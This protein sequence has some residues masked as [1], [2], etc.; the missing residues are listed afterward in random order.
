MSVIKTSAVP[1]DST[2]SPASGGYFYG[3]LFQFLKTDGV[4]GYKSF[5]YADSKGIPTLGV[6]YALV[7]KGKHGAWVVRAKYDSELENSGIN[8][9]ATQL[10][11]L[12]DDLQ[13]AANA[14]N[15]KGNAKSPFK[16]NSPI[17]T[18]EITSSQ[19]ESLFDG[20]INEYIQ[21]VKS[22][23][24][25]SPAGV[26]AFD[27]LYNDNYGSRELI[28]IASQA[29]NS[30]ALI[31]PG[32]SPSLRAAILDGN[33][34]EAWY[35]IRYNDPSPSERRYAEAA[36]FG[37]YQGD[38]SAVSAGDALQIYQMCTTHGLGAMQRYDDQHYKHLHDAEII[39]FSDSTFPKAE[40]LTTILMPAAQALSTLYGDGETFDSM[41]IFAAPSAGDVAISA[42]VNPDHSAP[43]LLIAAGGNDT[44]SGSNADDVLVAS[45]GNDLLEGG[46]GNDR[47]DLG[48]LNSATNVT[49]TI[50]DSDGQGS[51]WVGGTHLA[52]GSSSTGSGDNSIWIA[53]DGT[54]YVFTPLVGG[55]NTNVGTLTIS[56][57]SLGSGD[58]I[59]IDDFDLTKA[60]GDKSGYLGIHLKRALALGAGDQQ[61]SLSNA[62]LMA[63]TPQT[64]T[65]ANGATQTFTV[66]A[67]TV[68][69]K[70]QIVQ[71]GASGSGEYALS[72]GSQ[73]IPL[74]GTVDVTIPA[75]QSRAT[76]TLVDLSNSDQ[77]DSVQLT[78][79]AADVD[80]SVTSN[81]LTVNFNAPSVG[82]GNNAPVGTLT[83]P[84]IYAAKDGHLYFKYYNEEYNKYRIVTGNTNSYVYDSGQYDTVIGG[85]GND[86]LD[87]PELVGSSTSTG[88]NDVVEGGGG[89]DTLT[90]WWGNNEIYADTKTSIA[91][92]LANR[93]G[94]STEAKGSLIMVGGGNNLVVGGHGN[95]AILTGDGSNT[96][97]CGPGADT[98]I[99]GVFH[100]LGD[101]LPWPDG[102]GGYAQVSPYSA[103]GQ[104][105]ASETPSFVPFSWSITTA[106]SGWT[107]SGL[108][109]LF[110]DST[111]SV[112]SPYHG[113]S[114]SGVP[115]GITN[116]TIFGGTGDSF[117]QLSNGD[118]YLDAGGGNDTILAGIGR[119]TIYGGAGNDTIDG[120]GGDNYIATEA[121]NDVVVAF[122]GNNTIVGGSGNDT[123]ISGDNGAKWA[124]SETSAKNYI[125]SGSGNS[126]ILGSGG[127]DTLVAGSGN[128]S[129]Y[130]GAGKELIEGGAGK[131]VLASGSTATAGSDTVIAGSGDSTLY[132]GTGADF[133]YGG[134]GTDVIH[135]GSGATVIYAGDGGTTAAPTQVIVG[136]GDTTVHGGSGVDSIVGGSGADTLIAG[137]GAA[138][139]LGGSGTD[140]LEAGNGADVLAAGSGADTL[141][142]GLGE[143]TLAGGSGSNTLIAGKGADTLVGGSG[144]NVYE[145][146]AGFGSA[147]IRP[148]SSNDVLRFGDG[149]GLSDL[150]VTGSL[151][152]AAN[153]V[154]DIHVADGGAVSIDGGLLGTLDRYEVSGTLYTAQQLIA[155]V[156][157]L[158]NDAEGAQGDLLFSAD[159]GDSLTGTGGEDTLAA[160]GANT[161]L[162]GGGGD[163]LFIVND[164]SEVVAEPNAGL[165]DT[166]QSSVSYVLPE[167][168]DLLELAGYDDLT[169][170]GNDQTDVITA[171]SGNDTL[172]AGAGIATLVGGAGDDTF[173]VNNAADVVQA[174][175]ISNQWGTDNTNA[176]DTSVSY[177]MPEHVQNLTGVGSADIVLTGGA[178]DGEIITANSGNDTLIAGTGVAE[179][180][181][182]AG[183][184]T[185]VVN[186]VKDT[187]YAQAGG[188]GGTVQT[189][190]SFVMPENVQYLSGTGGADIELTAN[191]QKGATVTAN[192]GND[193][194]AGGGGS[195][196]LVGG[197]GV[198]TFVLGA[199]GRYTAEKQASAD[200]VV[201]LMP[202]LDLASDVAATRSGNDLLLT[203]GDTSSLKLTGYF[204]NPQQ[205]TIEDSL[206][207]TATGSAL[208]NATANDT[209]TPLERQEKIFET[210]VKERHVANLISE[211]Y[212]QQSD[213]SW[214][215]APT[216]AQAQV[217]AKETQYATTMRYYW[218]STSG[219]E[220]VTTSST[221]TGND[222]SMGSPLVQDTRVSFASKVTDATDSVIYATAYAS[223]TSENNDWL[224]IKW[225]TS[226]TPQKTTATH[227][228]SVADAGGTAV[229]P[230]SQSSGGSQTGWVLVS[231]AQ[232][233][234]ETV[235]YKVGQPDGSV[236]QA[237]LT[238][239]GN[240]SS[241]GSFPQAVP[242]DYYHHSVTDYLQRIDVGVGNHTV[243]GASSTLVNAG[244]GDNL[245]KDAGF[246]VA[247][248]GNDTIDGSGTIFSE[249]GNDLINNASIVYGGSGNDTVY[250]ADSVYGGSGNDLIVG[251]S[252]VVGGTGTD[253]IYGSGSGNTFTVDAN[254]GGIDV[255]GNVGKNVPTTSFVVENDSGIVD[256]KTEWSADTKFLD[257]Y[258][259]QQNISD[260]AERYRYG[261]MY[262][263]TWFGDGVKE[264]IPAQGIQSFLQ[265]NGYDGSVQQALAAG[266]LT[267]YI[268]PLPAA[269]PLVAL[270]DWDISSYYASVGRQV[271]Q[272]IAANDFSALA[273]YFDDGS[274]SA[275]TVKFGAG[276]TRSTLQ[277]SW[278][279]VTTDVGQQ[280]DA[281]GEPVD[282]EPHAALNITWSSGKGVQIIIPHRDD[283]IGSG[284][285]EF[286]FADGTKLSM[287]QMLAL[288]P[289]APT[290][291]PEIFDFKAGMGAQTLP[292]Y[293]QQI[294]FGTGAAPSD[295]AL[296]VDGSDLL[297]S[298]NGGADVLRITGGA[299][300]AAAV[301]ALTYTFA[302]GDTMSYAGDGQGGGTF[303][304]YDTQGD[305]IGDLWVK[306]D[307]SHGT[308]IFNADGSSSGTSYN[309]DGSYSTYT[310]DGQ[311]D[312][313]TKDYSAAGV[314]S[315]DSWSK[316][317][318]SHGTDT[319]NADGSS[320]GTAY[321]ADGSYSTY[322]NDGQ[323]DVTTLA[324][325]ANGQYTGD[326]W[327]R[328]D[329]SH[330]T[331]AFDAA[332]GQFAGSYTLA[333]GSSVVVDANVPAGN[334]PVVS[335]TADATVAGG[336]SSEALFG[337]G[338]GDTLTAGSAG[339]LVYGSGN[340]DVLQSGAGND[341]LIGTGND[342]T[343]VIGAGDGVDT[344]VAAGSGDT[345]VF[346]SGITSDMITLGIGSL[347]L[348]IGPDGQRVHIEG[349]DPS[350]ALGSG[351][352][353]NFRF[354]DGTVL[355]YDQLLARGFDL[356][357]GSGDVSLS[358]TD[359][360]NRL[361]GGSGNDTLIGTGQNDTLYAGSAAD[362]LIGG[363]GHETFVVNNTADVVQ[364]QAGAAGNVVE[365]SVSYAAPANVT[366]LTGT[367]SA[368]IVLTG[369]ALDD[370]IT[371]NSGSDTLVAGG[372]ADTLIGGAGGDTFVVDNAADVVQAQAV[373]GN[374]VETSV[375][376][377]APANVATLTGIGSADITLT[378][379]ALDDTITAN[380]G[381][382]TLVAGSVADTLIGGAGNDTF[383]VNNA[384][385]VVENAGGGTGTVLSSVSYTL[386]GTVQNLTLTGDA[387]IDGTGNAQSNDLTGN[388]GDNVLTG[389]GGN[390][391][392][393]GGAGN[394]TLIGGSG[395]DTFV[396]HKGDG[397]DTL[398]D[399]AG[400]NSVSLGAGL[401][402]QNVSLR[403]YM[404]DGEPYKVDADGRGEV[405]GGDWRRNGTLMLT[406]QLRVL[407]AH[408]DEQPGEGM[409]FTVTLD[410]RGDIVSPIQDFAFA[411][412]S[413]SSFSDL[414][415]KTDTV[416]GQWWDTGALVGG[417]NDDLIFAGP[418]NSGVWAGT[419]NDTVYAAWNGSRVYGGGG[420]DVLVG[421]FGSDTL[422]G[423]W[424][425][426]V[427]EGGAGNDVLSDPGGNS[428][429]FGGWGDDTITAGAGD[430]FIAGGAGD[431]VIA[432]GATD[433]VIAFD[434]GDGNDTLLAAAGADNTLSLGQVRDRELSFSKNGE[435]LVL[436][437]GRGDSVTF[438][439]WYASAANHDVGTL[440]IV[441]GWDQ[442]AGVGAETY[443]FAKLAAEFDRARA[444]DP[445]LNT[446]CLSTGLADAETSS[447]SGTVANRWTRM[448]TRLDVHLQDGDPSVLGG[449]LAYDYAMQGGFGVTD[450]SLA[451]STLR[452]ERF[453]H[454]AQSSHRESMQ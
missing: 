390:D 156:Q 344:I 317:D 5:V 146:D 147:Y 431:D 265:D 346:G 230:S 293:A 291:D 337:F 84:N 102:V 119:N 111:V 137:N 331:D 358:G 357:A 225:T 122:G 316:A 143:A 384:A 335:T 283:P 78:A 414:L 38:G 217:V 89:Q 184:D 69:D 446:W 270:N 206:G 19:A 227:L 314:L 321:N 219:G 50:D 97:I 210:G 444:A 436:H 367:G 191:D 155:A 392:F 27:A 16:H 453:G 348:R 55:S 76:F 58:Q 407:D 59:V 413:S 77:A 126:V 83:S 171:N 332:N 165:N 257:A 53:G 380:S 418:N 198:D 298:A 21:N 264:Y 297:L 117:Y 397:L 287:A 246:V 114:Y 124:T 300:D 295:L 52:G 113:G 99:G 420:D 181:G 411:D 286:E 17:Y 203:V 439:D 110:G 149:I 44:L 37:L 48:A 266:L 396:Y 280:V 275:T 159:A 307:G 107:Y 416:W 249:S 144:Q 86:W 62:L 1:T 254:V 39:P 428:A 351:S 153:L 35:Q 262:L 213:G 239:P 285:Q 327:Q 185:F 355:T 71:I 162:T 250:G 450:P 236:G 312:L 229:T 141:R 161:T 68:S 368:D 342:D 370:T 193:T 221:S 323:G 197:S 308:D 106:A 424:G 42:Q 243:Y 22:W 252:S 318:G 173:V 253:T 289:T 152:A 315:G 75:G 150:S 160:Y 174:Q 90:S 421:G 112:P 24:G 125:F 302:N 311:G 304:E 373:S 406:A 417:R 79:S 273:P 231:A 374:E 292:S 145:L 178:T 361:Y 305:K 345:I 85:S 88:M 132:G 313:T 70:D 136:S 277:F 296:S 350:D 400:Q 166:I 10:I 445:S 441:D 188:G 381:D 212:V 362:T 415:I 347:M 452:D 130:G 182:G 180:D 226:G 189:S 135:G 177:V 427:V 209:E 80:G 366:T 269:A 454:T 410:R 11:R 45:T 412:G 402:A 340:G 303:T 237:V 306:S 261:G 31:G 245:I 195:G 353:Q 240:L 128:A 6:G 329:G 23:L 408:G 216:L 278:S 433:N 423:G 382:D 218:A 151:D 95:D 54:R 394:D 64:A 25:S 279:V 251:A 20:I 98:V 360:D 398:V 322:A 4:E 430:D 158:N 56:G 260:G 377:A 284:I 447:D 94:Q 387:D 319:F 232:T 386:P 256:F 15:K 215:K 352:I 103:E 115:L 208:V 451:Q 200:A 183:N 36:M 301:S 105:L 443:D 109:P 449:A 2:S 120:A 425:V 325:D 33:R 363:Q 211:G 258:Y 378:G 233:T 140:V 43:S 320:S 51:V 192:A 46:A 404:P 281:L 391:T 349:F 372:G 376:Y 129:I 434:R 41:H 8:L 403:L 104:V 154:L 328:A 176:V 12:N 333:S 63:G 235:T 202:G 310:N 272:T 93:S 131:D 28:A 196:T 268:E 365:T 34:A 204:S 401:S 61:L 389:A 60:Q 271:T 263:S 190:V 440:Q 255:I 118:N 435:D 18:W 383:V 100:G 29:Y 92:A 343:F 385:D 194:L 101:N 290:F 448:N 201:K 248:T 167:N 432:T 163:T 133:L 220:R 409:D 3:S 223:V 354:A 234:V 330:G 186:N 244:S 299:T 222:F 108:L 339:D 134:S 32:H 138:T 375:S 276:I 336:S 294:V 7:V 81:Q 238:S 438:K 168:V 422:N 334:T 73:L 123:I 65:V 127:S 356:Y 179:L 187:V 324:Y 199:A 91:T 82:S 207:N 359:L 267:R 399:S 67:S 364:A 175:Q 142:G 170:K 9:S 224:K 139:L 274:L 172:V 419:G 148:V 426:D 241:S 442:W 57:G 309:A 288:A 205:W 429:L 214:Y 116:D 49:D 40:S 72:L 247:G 371:A 282:P 379:N 388:A 369:N 393:A 164:S 157:K 338:N 326:Q 47:Y 242:L 341:T 259:G 96:I 66:Y 437:A 13:K 169:G 30:P 14:L 405:V 87:I 395:N 26:A 74:T 228:I 121:G